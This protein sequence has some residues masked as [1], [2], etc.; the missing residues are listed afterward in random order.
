M[1]KSAAG[2][3][4]SG[5]PFQK[6][7]VKSWSVGLRGG[8][9]DGVV[10]V[11]DFLPY[12][13]G[14][15]D[16]LEAD[17]QSTVSAN[18]DIINGEVAISSSASGAD[19]GEAYLGASRLSGLKLRLTAGKVA[20]FESRFKVNSITGDNLT[21]FVGLLESAKPVAANLI[22]D[23]DDLVANDGCG[24]KLT[25]G[26]SSMDIIYG[27]DLS[28]PTTHKAAAHVL[29]AD[30]YVNFGLF[31]DGTNVE[32]FVDGQKSGDSVALASVAA[33]GVVL[34]SLIHI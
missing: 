2:R 12:V 33:D 17:A 16:E 32:F 22:T 34:L 23:A 10:S 29:V 19:D 28:N 4:L 24:I 11:D 27:P 31:C 3:I 13:A 18:N 9:R 30:T 14:N 26:L 1:H 5:G 21:I 7:A 6:I 8:G 20:A 25:A 15:Y